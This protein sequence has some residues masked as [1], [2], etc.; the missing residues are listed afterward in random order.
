MDVVNNRRDGNDCV[1]IC[2]IATLGGKGWKL[3]H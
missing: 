2:I 1:Y 3:D